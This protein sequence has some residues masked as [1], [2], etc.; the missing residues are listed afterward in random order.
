MFEKIFLPYLFGN[1]KKNGGLD[2]LQRLSDPIDT[3]LSLKFDEVKEVFVTKL[4]LL[5]TRD[6]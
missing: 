2:D 3:C 1:F 6:L 5:H 4:Q